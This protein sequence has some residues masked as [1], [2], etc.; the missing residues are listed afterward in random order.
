MENACIDAPRSTDWTTEE[1]FGAETNAV[2]EVCFE[3]PNIENQGAQHVTRM[4]C[5]RYGLVHV[6]NAQNSIVSSVTSDDQEYVEPIPIWKEYLKV[7]PS[8]ESN[9]ATLQS[10]LDQMKALGHITGY[11]RCDS[12][13]QVRQN[14]AMGRL[15]YTGSQNGDWTKVTNEGRYALR[16]D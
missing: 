14:I 15:I 5:T 11:V 8:A 13:A 3:P 12:E 4:A 10:S 9:G 2:R 6:V 16:T 7:D 1:V